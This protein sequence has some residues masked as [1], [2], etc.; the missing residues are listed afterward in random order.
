MKYKTILII[1]IIAFISSTLLAFKA[2]CDAQNTCEAIQEIPHS[3]VGGI[4]N[5][6]LGMAIFLFMSLITFSHIKNPRRRKKA[7]IHVGLIIGSVIALYFLYLQQFVF[8]A[9]CKYCV[10]IDLGV[11]IALVIAIFT[12]KK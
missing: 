9:Y 4:N 7:I 12:W 3:F 1:F 5:G 10:V 8:N 6:Y 2:P 11:L